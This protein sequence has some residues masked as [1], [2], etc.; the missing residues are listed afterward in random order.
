MKRSFITVITACMIAVVALI[1]APAADAYS[2]YAA[3]GDS[4][5]AGAGL[6]TSLAPTSEDSVCDRSTKAY[7]YRVAAAIGADLQQLACSG[8]K[9]DEGIYDSQWRSGI[10]LPPQ[11][12]SAFSDGT[13]DL[14]TMTVGA[15]DARWVQFLLQC[16]IIVCGT[17]FDDA[18]AKLYRADLRVELYWSL[19]NI[20]QMS[21]GTPPTVLLT[22]Y[23]SPFG[24]DA[25]SSLKRVKPEEQAWIRSQTA[26]LNQAIYSVTEWFDNAYYVD[27]NF[28]GHELCSSSPW[29]QGSSSPAPF[30]PNAAGQRAI[31]DAVL[32]TLGY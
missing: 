25:C 21:A 8:A 6:S 4:V 17:S 29:V 24:E 14:I 15:N 32:T 7:P 28:S 19:Y 10:T 2:T 16:Q 9:V 23:Y 30:H 3:M 18:R 5:A 27:V 12:D 26:D 31:G 1:P 20:E 13:P 11:F 22:G